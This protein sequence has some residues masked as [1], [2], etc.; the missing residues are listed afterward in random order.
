MAAISTRVMLLYC[1]ELDAN[2][3]WNEKDDTLGHSQ[4]SNELTVCFG[5][6]IVSSA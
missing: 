6:W 5:D 3:P 1:F 4:G 2:L